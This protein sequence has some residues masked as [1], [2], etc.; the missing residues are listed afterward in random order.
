MRE[1]PVDLANHALAAGLRAQYGLAVTEV[2]FLPLGHDASAWVYQVHAAD[3]SYFLKVRRGVTNPASLLVPRYLYDHG[4]TRVVAPLPTLSGDLW[5]M[6]QGY[7]AILY[8]FVEGVTGM[9]RGMTPPQWIAYGAMLRQIHDT[10]VAP[11]L[12][13]LMRRETFA[14]VGAALAR[15]LDARIAAGPFDDPMAGNLAGFWRTRRDQILLLVTR[16]V[17]LGQRLA[18]MG[19]P[20]VLCHADIHT[21]NV[22]LDA[23]GQVCIVDWDE[24]VLA[25][26]ERDLMFAV[27]GGISRTLVGPREQELF[28]SGYRVHTLDQLALTYYRYA[29]AVSDIADYA[30]QVVRGPDPGLVTRQAALDALI[31]LFQPGQIV[32]LAVGSD[33]GAG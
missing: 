32:E 15:D 16:A 10:V 14:P 20:S 4:V 21:A 27:G 3:H 12:A 8:P 6:V 33:A 30:A 31:G 28:L 17:E 18:H 2:A 1:P 11:D 5:A 29:W 23:A 25:P 19:L 13:R 24:T 26:R 7:A 9:E 22:L